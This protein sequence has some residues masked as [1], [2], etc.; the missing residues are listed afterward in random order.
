M[1]PIKFEFQINNKLIFGISMS[2]KYMEHTYTKKKK[3]FVIF[4]KFNYVLYIAPS[5]PIFMQIPLSYL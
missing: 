3:T 2:V 1:C 5:S 4:L